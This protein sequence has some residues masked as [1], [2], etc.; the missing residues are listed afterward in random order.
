MEIFQG[1]RSKNLDVLKGLIV[2]FRQGTKRLPEIRIFASQIT[3]RQDQQGW[4]FLKSYKAH[5]NL[6]FLNYHIIITPSHPAW[7]ETIGL[8]QWGEAWIRTQKCKDCL[9]LA[10]SEGNA[11]DT[12]VMTSTITW[13][14]QIATVNMGYLAVSELN[15]GQWPTQM[16]LMKAIV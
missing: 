14:A 16:I 5:N 2:F 8:Y 6:I 13:P 11:N 1:S 4:N 9:H 3:G 12:W 10:W 15:G 7:T